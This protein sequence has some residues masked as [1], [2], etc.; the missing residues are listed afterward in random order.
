MN[1]RNCDKFCLSFLG[2]LLALGSLGV[3]PANA[4]EG[5]NGDELRDTGRV[6][7]EI[8]VT[9]TY[10][11]TALMDTPMAMSSL[12]DEMLDTK[13]IVGIE[14]LYESIPSMSFKTARGT[15]NNI[16]IRG[17]GTTGGLSLV[18][19]YLDEVPVTD[20]TEFAGDS[21]ISGVLFDLE[22]VEVLKGPQGTLYGE[23]SVGGLIRYITKDANP[24]EFDL[25]LAANFTSIDESDDKGTR[26]NAVAN[27]PLLQDKLGLRVSAYYRDQPGILDI[28]APRNEDDVDDQEDEGVRVKLNWY[29]TERLEVAFMGN[30][31]KSNFGGPGYGSFAYGSTEITG[32]DFPNGGSDEHKQANITIRYELDWGEFVS[33]SSYFER[34]AQLALAAS[35]T[36]VTFGYEG[37]VDF[38]RFARPDLG[39]PDGP[40]LAGAGGENA[41]LRRSERFTQEFRLISSL[42]SDWS[43][44]AGLYFSDNQGKKNKDGDQVLDGFLLVPNPGFEAVPGALLAFFGGSTEKVVEREEQSVFGEL[45]YRFNANWDLTLGAR[46]ARVETDLVGSGQGL[47]DTFVSP[48]AI[49]SWRPQDGLMIYG[50]VA[51]GFRQGVFNLELLG[52]IETLQNLETPIPGGDEWLAVNGSAFKADGDEV[53]TFELG[54]KTGFLDNRVSLAGA[55]YYMEWEDMLMAQTTAPPQLFGADVLFQ[56]NTG[57]AHSQGI[58][59][60]VSALL[61]DR[62][63]WTVGGDYNDEAQLDSVERADARIYVTPIVEGQRLFN[64]PKYSWN[65]SLSYHL[66]FNNGWELDARA[67]W[68]RVAEDFDAPGYHKV[69]TRFTLTNA[70]RS[71]RLALFAENLK[72]ET[73]VFNANDILGIRFGQPRTIG[74]EVRYDL[75][76]Y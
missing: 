44:T 68:Y 40:G 51:Q 35:N 71:V 33:S 42:E 24:N 70:E 11:D 15:Y 36:A 64:S 25:T 38:L 62:L 10:R 22:R 41:F 76:G 16:T 65:T 63:T 56:D 49:L 31:M 60:E 55:I 6:L 12:T 4:S 73:I 69:N 54:I 26:I 61:S 21:Q 47:E 58:E 5:E 32:S 66:P 34:E 37:L 20:Q 9:S 13:G 30:Y 50:T 67:D 17:L 8:I 18:S 3:V 43:W 46:I 59:L 2:S 39:L 29:P 27:I 57:D 52:H 75:G 53:T 48:K 45:N 14:T 7:E 28:A 72:N 19:V 74:L 23:G 1:G